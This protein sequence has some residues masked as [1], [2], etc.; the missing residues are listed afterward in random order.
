[1]DYAHFHRHNLSWPSRPGP[2]IGWSIDKPREKIVLDIS[3]PQMICM[4]G[5]EVFLNVG[6]QADTVLVDRVFGKHNDME[7]GS[8]EIERTYKIWKQKIPFH[9]VCP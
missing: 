3:A 7:N 2:N 4:G 6:H 8:S 1:M 9:R 5:G